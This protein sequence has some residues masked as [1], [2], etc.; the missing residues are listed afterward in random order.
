MDET[1]FDKQS[2]L[3]H[4]IGTRL[5]YRS[6][7]AVAAM[8]AFLGYVVMA[9]VLVSLGLIVTKLLIPGPVGVWDNSVNRWAAAHRVPTWNTLTD[10]ASVL[11][12]TGT[13]L[14]IAG[15]TAASWRSVV[16]GGSWASWRTFF[17]EFSVFLTT[18]TL[19]DRHGRAF[20]SSTA[21]R[22]HRASR[23]VTWLRDRL[24]VGLA[25]LISSRTRH[26]RLRSR[27]G[28]SRWRWCQRR[29]LA[30]VPRSAPPHRCLRRRRARDRRDPFAIL[31]IRA[32]VA[33]SR[34]RPR[35]D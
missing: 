9:I 14:I 21:S 23:R 26:P 35:S 19:I 33:D 8:V 27:C 29:C 28:R 10:Y 31:A 30:R 15:A 6:P 3:G 2:G 34:I 17:I 22:R 20:R 25:I 32:A 13:V 18:V 5:S 24:Y 4:D 16:S 11:A 12:G 1:L 7:R